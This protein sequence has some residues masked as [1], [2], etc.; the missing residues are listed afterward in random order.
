[1]QLFPS[2]RNSCAV[3]LISVLAACGG[4]QLPLEESVDRSSKL[5][6]M[7]GAEASSALVLPGD[8]SSYTLSKTVNGYTIA[9]NDRTANPIVPP[10]LKRIHFADTSLALDLETVGPIYR[11]YQ[12]AFNRKPDLPGLGFWLAH[13]EEGMSLERIAAAF[14]E[15]AEFRTLYGNSPSDVQFVTALYNNVLHR[16]PEP[17]GLAFWLAALQ[18]G[19][20][21]PSVLVQFAESAENLAQVSS[22]IENGIVFANPAISYRPVG[23]AGSDRAVTVGASVPLDASASTDANG[24]PLTLSWSLVAPAGSKATLS[25]STEVAAK[26]QTDIAGLYTVTLRVSDGKNSGLPVNI[27]ITANS[28]PVPP[29]TDTGLYKCTAISQ[30]LARALYAAG[31][32]YLDRDH[33]GKPCEANDRTL[34]SV[35][36]QPVTPPSSGMCWVNGYTRRNGTYVKGYWRRC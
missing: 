10:G 17:A 34:E 15:S 14:I 12:A 29:I 11:L 1:M 2:L 5:L 7:S 18:R 36:T 21:R 20:T 25:P 4:G 6:A 13:L 31:H 30:E 19:I 16:Q 22:S 32:T 24:D 35:V 27:T 3:F 33:D 9:S 8:M 28:V 23:R 26:L